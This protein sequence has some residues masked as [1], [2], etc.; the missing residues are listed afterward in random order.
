MTNRAHLKQLRAQLTAGRPEILTGNRVTGAD[1]KRKHLAGR[2]IR[3][4]LQQGKTAEEMLFSLPAE[5]AEAEAPISTHDG[6]WPYSENSGLIDRDLARS[7]R[8][9]ALTEG[10]NGQPMAEAELHSYS[11]RQ[12][13]Q[14]YVDH[15]A[16]VLERVRPEMAN[17]ERRAW[18]LERAKYVRG[19]DR[20]GV[21]SD[22]A[23]SHSQV[24]RCSL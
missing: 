16:K 23:Q 3:E 17:P 14:M 18:A 6:K 10:A 22:A 12:L 24:A 5:I 1:R 11:Q 19:V 7:I 15:L 20:N 4:Q 9:W 8:V 13:L 2:L 21:T